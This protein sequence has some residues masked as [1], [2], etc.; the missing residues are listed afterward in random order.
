MENW[1]SILAPQV[2][3]AKTASGSLRAGSPECL[4][5]PE[6][7]RGRGISEGNICDQA[8]PEGS[9]KYRAFHLWK[10]SV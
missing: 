5:A 3:R 1:V 10:A 4:T 7:R 9:A 6:L 8:P 2:S